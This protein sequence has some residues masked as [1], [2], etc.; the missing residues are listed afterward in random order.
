MSDKVVTIQK[1]LEEDL[2][3]YRSV[4]SYLEANVPI[5][6]LCLPKPIENALIDDGCLRVYDLFNRD[7]AKIKGIGRNRLALLT[8]RLDQFFSV[9]I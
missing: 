8:S 4:L 5:Q 6:V 1:K 7:L 3:H 2:S 9:A